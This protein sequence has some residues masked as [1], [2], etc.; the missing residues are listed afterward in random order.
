MTY[1]FS[2]L[3]FFVIAPS[4]I[5]WVLILGG[6]LLQAFPRRVVLGRRMSLF[7][8]G[9]MLVLG[10]SPLAMVLLQPLEQ[11]FAQDRV[12]ARERAAALGDVDGIILLGGF[13][14]GRLSRLRGQIAVNES[15]ERLVETARIA[16]LLPGA[17][18]IFTGGA[19]GVF[20][21]YETAGGSVR[22]YLID[23]G[24]SDDR[25]VI[26]NQSRN[27]WENAL[28]TRERI[29]LVAG[30]RY[31]L[32]TSAWH[33]PRAVGAF[34]K[35]G[36]TIVPWPADFRTGDGSDAQRLFPNITTGLERIDLAV[37]EYVGLLAYWILGRTS[38]L[39][40]SPATDA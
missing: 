31:V 15:A 5:C 12:S 26:E 18:I 37:K 35:A 9:L 6:V 39:F 1:I 34:R 10:F 29:Q 25:I 21:S 27:T 17:K 33:M 30:Q 38:A 13:E 28:R 14:D 23:L 3:L 20:Q 4:N 24:I 7:G 22:S 2:K 40:P 11:R 36:F 19:A 16:K 32:V 8:I